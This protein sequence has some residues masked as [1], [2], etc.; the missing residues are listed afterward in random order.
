LETPAVGNGVPGSFTQPI[1]LP[2]IHLQCN[3]AIMEY[4]FS[5]LGLS[6]TV[7][8]S[9]SRVQWR[10]RYFWHGTYEQE[11]PLS[12]LQPEFMR[13]VG[14]ATNL[15]FLVAVSA[16]GL[17]VAFNLV[18]DKVSDFPSA[19]TAAAISFTAILSLALFLRYRKE[20][21]INF[22]SCDS[23]YSVWFCRRGPDS[24]NFSAFTSALQDR[25]RCANGEQV[26]VNS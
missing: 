22:R 7:R 18:H 2:P 17:F 26:Q 25:I 13:S 21:W 15:G 4:R 23:S 10:C 5:T 12:K 11:I 24:Q 20:E 14:P 6:G 19:F 1:P 3:R 8:L 9:D 16:I